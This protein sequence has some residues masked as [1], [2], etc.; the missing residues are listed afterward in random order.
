MSQLTFE[1]AIAKLEEIIA[2][3]EGG[4]STLDAALGD[5]EE[6]IG[7]VRLCTEMLTNAEKKLT[8][9]TEEEQASV[10]TTTA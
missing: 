10:D 5:Y 9:L 7:L 8:V 3:M 1:E 4:K 2:R 6:A